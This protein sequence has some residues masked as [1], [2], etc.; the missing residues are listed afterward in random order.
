VIQDQPRCLDSVG[1]ENNCIE[2]EEADIAE[3]LESAEQVRNMGQS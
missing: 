3:E 2:V 1:N